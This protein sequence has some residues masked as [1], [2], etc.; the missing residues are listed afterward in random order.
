M[1][2]IIGIQKLNQQWTMDNPFLFGAHHLEAYPKG[3]SEMGPA[4]SL[5][6]RNIGSDFSGKDGF[7]MYHGD[8]I[9][10][11]PAHPHRGFE[12]V[13]I[14]QTGIVDHFDSKG[15]EG[16][17]G[18]GDVQWMTAGSGCQHNEMF[19]L[20]NQDKENP[21]ELFQLW[22]NLPAKSKFS[23]PDYQM[24][25]SEDIPEIK[26]LDTNG[27]KTTIR[28]I[29]GNFQDKESLTPNASSWANDKKNHVGIFMIQLEPEAILTLPA[30]SETLNRN[31]YYYRGIGTI[32]IEDQQIPSSNRIKLSGNEKIVITNGQFE[33]YLILLE[34]EPI[35]EPVAHYG[36]FVM[37]TET[38]I[39][40]AMYD[41]QQTAFGGWPWEKHDQVHERHA[42]RFARYSDGKIENR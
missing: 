24:F 17:Y 11:F 4:V 5:V 23:E 15:N 32:Q 21:M 30:V 29:A 42:R 9:P 37:N 19:P 34:G 16:R 25:W 2:K 26:L 33:S 36:P 41:Y 6:G 38:E 14:A 27:N 28:L 12:T 40:Q 13:T 22:L 3:N 35:Q 18:N 7:S 1:K 8:V 10:G 31:L 39:R 20:V